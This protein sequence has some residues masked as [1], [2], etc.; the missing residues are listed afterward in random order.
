MVILRAFIESDSCASWIIVWTGDTL[1]QL[2]SLTFSYF[3]SFYGLKNLHLSSSFAC[4]V[5]FNHYDDDHY[6][7]DFMLF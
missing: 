5:S 1:C 4:D 7:D 6:D 2:D 3:K